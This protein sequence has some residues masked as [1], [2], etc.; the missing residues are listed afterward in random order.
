[1]WVTR[2]SDTEFLAFTNMPRVNGDGSFD[3]T[4]AI[5]LEGRS[6]LPLRLHCV[7]GGFIQVPDVIVAEMMRETQAETYHDETL[8]ALFSLKEG[9]SHDDAWDMVRRVQDR[10]DKMES[11]R[12]SMQ[13]E[14]DYDMDGLDKEKERI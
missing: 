8:A 13:D 11:N 6:F 5:W 7:Y 10:R 3:K 4:G 2:W 14:L 12:M 9:V 1:M